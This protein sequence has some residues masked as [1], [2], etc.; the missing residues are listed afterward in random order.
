MHT[1]RIE[2]TLRGQRRPSLP[3]H[4]TD[5]RQR[6]GSYLAGMRD[7]EGKPRWL[8]CDLRGRRPP[9]WAI[10]RR[11]TCTPPRDGKNGTRAGRLAFGLLLK[12]YRLSDDIAFRFS[13]RGLGRV[14]PLGGEVRQVGQPDQRRRLPVQPV[15]GLRDLRRAPV[16][17]HGHL[18]LPRSPAVRRSSMCQ[19]GHHRNHF[20]TPSRPCTGSPRWACTT[21]P[22]SSP[23]P[24]PSAT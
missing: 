7:A 24:T 1:Q 13:N 22:T 14:A 5:L 18:R 8:G 20:N 10:A 17:R 12:N 6:A 21:R 2:N 9:F 3:Q 15:H 11:T 16:G 4:R 19:A 23:G